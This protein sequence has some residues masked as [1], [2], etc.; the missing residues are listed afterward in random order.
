MSVE[1]YMR[2]FTETKLVRKVEIIDVGVMSRR[3]GKSLMKRTW[4]VLK[5]RMQS[6][7]EMREQLLVDYCFMYDEFHAAEAIRDKILNEEERFL[8][9]LDGTEQNFLIKQFELLEE[10]TRN[11]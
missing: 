4:K 9:V 11:R 6:R 1:D 10:M 5:F 3:Q 2:I 8:R 7:E